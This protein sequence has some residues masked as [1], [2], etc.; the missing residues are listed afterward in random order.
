MNGTLKIPQHSVL[1]LPFS[2]PF[3]FRICAVAHLTTTLAHK[4]TNKLVVTKIT[5]LHSICSAN[6]VKVRG[7]VAAIFFGIRDKQRWRIW[8]FGRIC[9]NASVGIFT[10]SLRLY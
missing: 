7:V 3:L 2:S 6:D 5:S 9:V 1:L 10:S 8:P 4:F